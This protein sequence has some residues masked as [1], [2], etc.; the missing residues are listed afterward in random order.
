MSEQI[1]ERRSRIDLSQSSED[2]AGALRQEAR[3][4]AKEEARLRG[5]QRGEATNWV[6]KIVRKVLGKGNNGE[7]I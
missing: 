1:P 2:Y 3:Q 7:D 6:A 4:A 5:H